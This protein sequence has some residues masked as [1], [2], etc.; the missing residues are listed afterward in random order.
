MKNTAATNRKPEKYYS[1]LFYRKPHN[2]FNG[3]N[4]IFDN[5]HKMNELMQTVKSLLKLQYNFETN[6]QWV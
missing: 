4:E 5:N 6:A 1:I 2:N 3:N